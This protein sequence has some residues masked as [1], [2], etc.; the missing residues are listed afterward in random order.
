MIEELKAKLV[1]VQTR[2]SS[3][4]H[5]LADS[6]CRADADIAR[7]QDELLKLRDR[8]DRFASISVY[9]NKHRQI[10]ECVHGSFVV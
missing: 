8:Y 4:E 10:V 3:A 5:E 7:L 2:A 9:Y 1:S 6:Q